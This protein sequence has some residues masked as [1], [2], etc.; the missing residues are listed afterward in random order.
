MKKTLLLMPLLV[1]L[2]TYAD[3]PLCRA[4]DKIECFNNRYE[5]D[6][7]A[8]AIYREATN[9]LWEKECG[10]VLEGKADEKCAT[11][12]SAKDAA[13]EVKDAN[14][15]F[16]NRKNKDLFCKRVIEQIKNRE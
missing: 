6:M 8:Q 15:V 4:G 5:Y 3:R 14:E 2:S 13:K 10:V 12:V 1:S 16:G 11:L 7:C 9:A